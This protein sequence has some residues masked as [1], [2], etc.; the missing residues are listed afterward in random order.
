MHYSHNSHIM[1]RKAAMKMTSVTAADKEA[2][3]SDKFS[4][5]FRKALLTYS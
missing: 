1:Q 2:C 3:S 4:V 5:Y